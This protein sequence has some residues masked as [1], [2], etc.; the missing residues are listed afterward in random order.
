MFRHRQRQIY[1]Q[2]I[3]E[4]VWNHFIELLTP[5]DSS[6]DWCSNWLNCSAWSKLLVKN[7]VSEHNLW[8][9]QIFLVGINDGLL[10]SSGICSCIDKLVACHPESHKQIYMIAI[11]HMPWVSAW[12][13]ARLAN[14][15]ILLYPGHNFIP[16]LW[17]I[18]LPVHCP[19]HRPWTV[20][21][22]RAE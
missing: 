4:Q 11:V 18:P 3:L 6:K 21:E 8:L 12:Y 14:V 2:Q 20:R 15:S 10:C 7:G 5:W 19:K 13:S 17:A 16:R 22:C 9:S 1:L